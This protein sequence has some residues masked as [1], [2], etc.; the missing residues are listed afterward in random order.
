[1]AADNTRNQR[2]YYGITNAVE[3]EKLAFVFRNANGS[4]E[5]KT[6]AGVTYS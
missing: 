3:V 4:K 6:A 1:M 5:G 2:E